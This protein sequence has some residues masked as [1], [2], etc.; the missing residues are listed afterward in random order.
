MTELP[1]ELKKELSLNFKK[2]TRSYK[3]LLK[4]IEKATWTSADTI[5]IELY[6]QTK[7]VYKRATIL[8]EM[9]RL[10]RYKII[11]KH[12]IFKSLYGINPNIDLDKILEMDI[13]D[14]KGKNLKKNKD[15]RRIYM[16]DYH[17]RRKNNDTKTKN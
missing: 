3:R 9:C 8:S 4:I 7:K 11:I 6:Y 12:P 14:Y 17:Q 2:K 13:R 10:K 5:L 1:K 16:K 15:K